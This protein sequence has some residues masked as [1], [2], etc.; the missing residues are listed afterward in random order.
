MPV[1]TPGGGA[2]PV[3]SANSR[4]AAWSGVSVPSQVPAGKLELA[5][6]RVVIAERPLEHQD[7]PRVRGEDSEPG[8]G[9]FAC[10]LADGEPAAVVEVV[11][12]H[13]GDDGEL[14][15]APLARAATGGLEPPECG[16]L[17]LHG[18]RACGFPGFVIVV[19]VEVVG[20]QARLGRDARAFA[21]LGDR[22]RG[23]RLRVRRD[24]RRPVDLL[25]QRRPVQRRVRLDAGGFLEYLMRQ[26]GTRLRRGGL[27]VDR[28]RHGLQRR[29]RD[30]ASPLGEEHARDR[31]GVRCR[32]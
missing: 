9:Y 32:P 24:G 21:F 31:R 14:E 5:R 23:L 17:G 10:G 11:R 25:R 15:V 2:H 30:R 8:H 29:Q 13:R 18:C 27:R 19:A 20:V 12:L 1:W 6:R 3:S 7:A 28:P 4:H 26:G 22:P 16:E